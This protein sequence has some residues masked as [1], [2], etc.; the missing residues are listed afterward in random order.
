MANP[1]LTDLIY[2]S[3]R[4]FADNGFSEFER[5]PVPV[6]VTLAQ[7]A[8]SIEF[9]DPA[10]LPSVPV[11]ADARIIAQLGFGVYF[12]KKCNRESVHLPE[13]ITDQVTAYFNAGNASGHKYSG[14]EIH[15]KITEDPANVT[16]WLLRAEFTISKCKAIITELFRKYKKTEDPAKETGSATVSGI[17]VSFPFGRDNQQPQKKPRGR[18]E[19][20]KEGGGEPSSAVVLEAI[21]D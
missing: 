5:T 13:R 10:L 11:S 1:V 7:S 14:E 4:T 18:K 9:D 6:S 3:M 20:A 16:D 12:A 21:S 15:E 8:T 19:A 17:P 2:N